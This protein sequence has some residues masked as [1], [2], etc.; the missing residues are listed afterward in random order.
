MWVNGKTI[1]INI[2]QAIKALPIKALTI[3]KI[4]A[5]WPYFLVLQYQERILTIYFL[6]QI[7][8]LKE[9]YFLA[10]ISTSQLKDKDF[11]D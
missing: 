1:Q 10:N 7:F 2:G 4:V 11:A 3:K 6:P 9:P 8:G 5:A